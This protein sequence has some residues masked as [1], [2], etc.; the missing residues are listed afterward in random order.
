MPE[1]LFRR[2]DEKEAALLTALSSRGIAGAE[3]F[4]FLKLNAG[5]VPEGTLF[6]A[7]KDGAPVGAALN[8]GDYTVRLLPGT[9][10]YEEGLFL[11]KSAGVPERG[12][13]NPVRLT[14]SNLLEAKTLLAGGMLSRDDELRYVYRARCMREGLST[15][16][17]IKDENGALLSFAFTVAENGDSALLGDVFTVPEARKRGL[18]GACVRALDRDCR[19]RGKTLWTLTEKENLPFYESLQFVSAPL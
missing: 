13:E 4:T 11:L 1:P 14:L 16:F 8:T 17:G 10:P 18:A 3:I 5:A 9:P 19:K 2:P 15:G 12:G 7:V 6:A